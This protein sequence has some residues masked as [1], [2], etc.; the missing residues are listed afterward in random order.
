VIFSSLTYFVFFA[1]VLAVLALS[2]NGAFKRRFLLVASYVFYAAWDW[3]FLG[4]LFGLTL[5]ND[6]GARAIAKREGRSRRTM[7]TVVVVADLAVLGVFKYFDFFAASANSMLSRVGLGVPLLGLLLPVGISFITFEV[8][9]YVV[10]VYRGNLQR[11]PFED[12]A[13]LVAFFPHLIAGPILKPGR[14]LPQLR[15]DVVVERDNLDAG[16]QQFVVG[17]V[18]KV[19]IADRLGV[20]VDPVMAHAHAYNTATLWLALAAYTVQIYCDFSGYSDRAS[21]S[22][23]CMGFDI[24][25]NFDAPYLSRNITEFWRRWHISLSTWL[26]EHIYFP[27][28][29]NR[30]GKARQALNIMVV[31][32]AAGLWHGASWNFVLWGGLHGAALA[33]HKWWMDNVAGRV[34]VPSAVSTVLASTLTFLFVML[35][36]V[37]FRVRDLNEAAYM[38]ERLL[39][40]RD[41]A[42]IAWYAT[43]ALIALPLVAAAHLVRLR[44]DAVPRLR[45]VTF[46]GAFVAAFVLLALVILAPAHTSPFIYFQF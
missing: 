28:G 25:P 22:A 7:L 44:W 12:L 38:L 24:P 36:W 32:L 18:K 4:L 35:A 46:R 23:R 5:L 31:M 29:G 6:L 17:M 27:L 15:R 37:L 8:I 11:A 20:F 30:K 34:K 14:F 19:L 16:M 1:V 2:R 39:F 13:L 43:S 9:S 42:G 45:L 41:S 10:D 26:R 21:G 33:V 3:R 40:I